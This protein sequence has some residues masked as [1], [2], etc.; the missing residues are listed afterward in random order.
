[1]CL[2]HGGAGLKLGSAIFMGETVF[3]A[4]G[5]GKQYRIW[6]LER[7]CTLRGTVAGLARAPLD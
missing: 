4:E 5:L 6:R 1:M 3:R 2:G 7:Y